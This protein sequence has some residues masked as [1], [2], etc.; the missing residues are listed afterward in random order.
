MDIKKRLEEEHS[1]PLTTA[2]VNFI[3]DDKK[4]FRVLMELFLIGEYRMT[5]RAAWPLS[6]V[7]I[8][9]PR[10][11][12]PY[13][14][15]LIEKLQQAENHPAIARNILRMFQAMDIPEKYHGILIDACFKFITD[16]ACPV[17]IRAFAITTA[18]RICLHYPELKNELLLII[19]DLGQFAQPPAISSR[20]KSALK[21]LKATNPKH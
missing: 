4:K 13:F 8:E 1:K 14:E 16:Q 15:K 2:I 18:A 7:A 12:T 5:Q 11:V 17:A 3:G 19:S 9:H 21:N 6:Y 10:L 20:I